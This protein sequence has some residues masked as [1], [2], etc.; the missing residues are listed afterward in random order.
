MPGADHRAARLMNLNNVP[1]P[2]ECFVLLTVRHK[3]I[4]KK[5]DMYSGGGGDMD[6]D[7]PWQPVSQRTS[8]GD[9]IA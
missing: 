4:S 9:S 2:E 5:Y 8:E 1:P 7:I 3:K 6:S